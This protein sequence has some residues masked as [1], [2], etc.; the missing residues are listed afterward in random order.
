MEKISR[1]NDLEISKI[2]ERSAEG[3]SH[4]SFRT[5]NIISVGNSQNVIERRL[6]TSKMTSR[7]I[8]LQDYQR[9]K[10]EYEAKYKQLILH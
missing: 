2:I 9:I 5:I 8:F 1:A 10:D 7:Q 3:V 6:N 4:S